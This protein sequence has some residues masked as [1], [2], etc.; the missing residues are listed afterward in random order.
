MDL[1]T[2]EF[3]DRGGIIHYTYREEVRFEWGYRAYAASGA[4]P[5]EIAAQGV[6]A[7][8]VYVDEQIQQIIGSKKERDRIFDE[9]RRAFNMPLSCEHHGVLLEGRVMCRDDELM[10]DLE[11]PVQGSEFLAWGSSRAG[12]HKIWAEPGITLTEEAIACAKRQLVEIY[13]RVTSP[14]KDL[15]KRLNE[16]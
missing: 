10:V 2:L 6:E 11:T 8:K 13:K 3:F 5:A 7:V 12:G 14:V 16:K 4:V 1:I 9:N 15:V